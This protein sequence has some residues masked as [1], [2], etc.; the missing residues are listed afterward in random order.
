M[1]NWPYSMT[2]PFQ[3]K[4]TKEAM[5]GCNQINLYNSQSCNNKNYDELVAPLAKRTIIG[6]VAFKKWLTGSSLCHS[7]VK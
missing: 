1:N 2:S 5:L 4:G 3:K 6:Q 7:V